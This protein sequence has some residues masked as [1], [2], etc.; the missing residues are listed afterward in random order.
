MVLL[1]HEEGYKVGDRRPSL[2]DDL[3]HHIHVNPGRA[4]DVCVINELIE[5]VVDL[6]T[7]AMD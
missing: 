3:G 6:C 4:T 7:P 2:R 5:P 1:L